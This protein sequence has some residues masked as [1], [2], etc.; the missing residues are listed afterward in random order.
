MAVNDAAVSRRGVML[1]LCVLTAA[2]AICGGTAGATEVC[3]KYHKC[4][5]FAAN[6]C[7]DET[8]S[9][10]V[11]KICYRERVK[12]LVLAIGKDK[13]PY[14]WCNVGPEV[15]A[16]LRAAPSMG[17]YFNQNI[18][19]GATGGKYDCRNFSIPEL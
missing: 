7:A 3:V 8:R 11:H 9:S 4:V 10:L 13:T 19:G 15:I 16:E 12:Y 2:L 5:T 6:E 17:K 18:V 14:H 1:R